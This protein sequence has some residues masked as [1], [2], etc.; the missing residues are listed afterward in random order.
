M[1]TELSER[2]LNAF[3]RLEDELRKV[4]GYGSH[5]SFSL[6]LDH[7]S[8]FHSGFSHYRDDLREY[9]ELRNAI[10]HKRIGDAPI[11]E[12]HPEIVERIESAADILTQTPRL[13]DHFRK[14]V[15]VCSPQ[16]SIKQVLVKMLKGH[17]NQIPVYNGKRIAGL[18]T[19]DA[20]AFWLAE[21]LQSDF[22]DGNTK[23]RDLIGHSTSAEN[24]AVLSGECSIFDA[25]DVF[26]KAHKRGKHLQAIIVTENGDSDQRPIGIITTLEVPSLITLVN[27]EPPVPVRRH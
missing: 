10:V 2:F 11:A 24:F 26:E 27:P 23:I 20:I 7:A 1:S 15:E 8:R 6:M 3:C 9:A 21:S 18:L 22:V 25:I 13:S 16:D 5:E 14:H 17:F 12:P 4:T 19:S